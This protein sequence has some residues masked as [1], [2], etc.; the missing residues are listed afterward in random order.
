MS[1]E[2]TEGQLREVISLRSQRDAAFRTSLLS[3]PKAA[4]ERLLGQS[5]P[6]NLAV[7]VLEDTDRRIH[8]VI[9]PAVSD[10]LSDDQL[11]MVAGGFLD[12]T[13]TGSSVLGDGIFCVGGGLINSK[14][15]VNL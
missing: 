11:E 4:V 1:Q 5:L 8:L 15:E 10:E 2:L 14:M 7:S 6:S 9:P 3:D 13:G 12:A